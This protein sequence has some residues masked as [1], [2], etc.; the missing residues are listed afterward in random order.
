[1]KRRTGK[2]VGAVDR[3]HE[4]TDMAHNPDDTGFCEVN[5][6]RFD[7]DCAEV[8]Y[9]LNAAILFFAKSIRKAQHEGVPLPNAESN[10]S[11]LRAVRSSLTLTEPE[12]CAMLWLVRYAT[13]LLAKFG[14][15]RLV[16][17]QMRWSDMMQA[18]RELDEDDAV[19]RDSEGQEGWG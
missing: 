3:T 16:L 6:E 9:H 5:G 1:M 10:I 19:V 2:R 13:K 12:E 8:A 18:I 4:D 7:R 14:S 17:E 11:T 15:C